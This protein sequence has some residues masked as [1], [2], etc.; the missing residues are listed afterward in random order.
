MS[1]PFESTRAKFNFTPGEVAKLETIAK[2]RTESLS[3]IER[4]KILLA[5]YQ[6]E[7]VSS[8]ARTLKINRPKAERH[9]SKALDLGVEAALEDLPRKGKPQ[10]ITSEARAWVVS[11]ACQKPKDLGYSY[12]LWTTRLLA[13]HIRK[14]CLELGFD[15]L[16]K[17]SRGTVSKIL[18]EN[19]IK[20]HKIQYYL[21]RRDPEFDQKMIQVLHVYKEVQVISAKGED[22]LSAYISYDE[23]PGIQAI[24]N[25]APDLPPSPGKHATVYRD[26][27]YV[28]HGTLSLLAG[29]DLL[30]GEVIA[31]VE[32]RHRSQ[33]VINFLKKLD[34]HYPDKKRITIVLDNHSA[35]TSKETR[36]YLATVPNR[37]E[38]VFTPKHGSWL[39]IIESFFGKLAKTV[40]RGI[41]VKSKNELAE[42]LLSCIDKINEFPVVYRWKYKM[43][44]ISVV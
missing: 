39:N 12:E 38:F 36:T 14:H 30:T 44:S 19:K 4:A 15:C 26:H 25:T 23:K 13:E 18:S 21:E 42:R 20:P 37:F 10:V 27:E 2:S 16:A 35:H 41:R 6:G 43:D 1:M 24:E 40:L 32:D 11:I 29:I 33:E 3:S 5:Y 8:I 28:R 22:S 9:I 34:A 7:T 31:T 17:L